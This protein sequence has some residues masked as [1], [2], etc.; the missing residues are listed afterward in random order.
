M[1]E[2]VEE[3]IKYDSLP[4]FPAEGFP[5]AD[6]GAT[7]VP[8]DSPIRT[9]PLPPQ[10]WFQRREAL[11][12]GSFGVA[13]FF[14]AWQAVAS[15]RIWSP[16]FLPGP[17]DVWQAFLE[18]INDGEL[19]TDIAVSGQEFVIGYALAALVGIPCCL[20]FGWYPRLRY[21]FDPFITFFYATPRI[22]LIPLFII[23][24]G[25]GVES[26]I[27]VIYLGAVFAILINTMA[28][29][30]SLDA[31]LLRVARS[32]GAGDLHIFRTIALP[33]SVP[34]ILTGLRLG[35]GHALIAVVVG[36]LLAAQ[37][38]IGLRIAIAGATFQ[39]AKVFAGVFVVASTGVLVT[40]LLSRFEARFD[41]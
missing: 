20:L 28:G 30:R 18:L 3:P 14:V 10:T 12:I 40:T 27:A 21:V 15:A 2:R 5:G 23:W 16:L 25:I 6:M 26:K 1:A 9:T 41:A 7:R 39:T 33:G 19:A 32:F 22:V 34:F 4:N 36:E 8:R 11:L 38:G 37:A 17:V 29:V 31:S 35:T 13:V 24:L